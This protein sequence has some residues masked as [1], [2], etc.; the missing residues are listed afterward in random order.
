MNKINQSSLKTKSTLHRQLIFTLETQ[1]QEHAVASAGKKN[2]VYCQL[3]QFTRQQWKV[4]CFG[5][6][7]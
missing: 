6:Y 1:S 3:M 4:T 5:D 2:P 7:S